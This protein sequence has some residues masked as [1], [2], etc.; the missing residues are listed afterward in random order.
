M[1]GAILIQSPK[2]HADGVVEIDGVH[3]QPF[4]KV[5]SNWQPHS[6]PDIPAAKGRLDVQLEGQS[7]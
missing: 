4:K 2:Q 7:L 6:I 1:H 5:L 3:S